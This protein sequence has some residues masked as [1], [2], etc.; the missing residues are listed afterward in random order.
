MGPRITRSS[1]STIPVDSRLPGGGGG[2]LDGLYNVTP[3][4]GDAAERQLPDA[5][6]RTSAIGRR[7]PNSLN[8]N[9]TARMRNGLMLQGG[10]NTRNVS[11]R[12]LR[13][14]GVPFRSGRWS[15]RSHRPTRGATR[16][17]GWVDSRNG[18]RL[19][20][21]SE[22]RRAGLRHAAQRSGRASWPRTGRRRTPRPSASTG[23]L[24][25]WA[26]RPITVNLIEPGT[27]Y[28]DRVNQIDMR[29]AKML[30][31]GRTRTN[32]RL[33][34]LQHRELRRGADLQP[35]VLADDRPRG[36]GR[37]ACLQARFMKFSAQMDF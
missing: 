23:R 20:H 4:G 11:Q 12:L 35:D 3:R 18:A 19:V 21:D 2:V 30:R 26:A 37:T 33:R 28:G 25:A 32:G 17:Q 31:F 1:A 15:L 14:A 5:R 9:V 36:C 6:P 22:G 27:L 13:R 34:R 7:S 10:F 8:L 29:F 16:R 24:P